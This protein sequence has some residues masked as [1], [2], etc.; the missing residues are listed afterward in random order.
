MFE[1]FGFESERAAPTLVRLRNC[2]F[3]PMAAKSAELVCSV[4]QAFLTGYLHGL[5]S[6]YADAVLAPLPDP[7]CVEPRGKDMAGGAMETGTTCG[8]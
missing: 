5:G 3:H 2:P 7:C 1:D 4:N 8:R 6:D